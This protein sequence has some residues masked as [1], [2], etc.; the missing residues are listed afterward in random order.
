MNIRETLVNV[1]MMLDWDPKVGYSSPRNEKHKL[2]Q[3]IHCPPGRPNPWPGAI[4]VR[5][6]WFAIPYNSRECFVMDP[7]VFMVYLGSMGL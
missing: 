6:T 2:L 7:F 3:W 5:C 1:P 4:A